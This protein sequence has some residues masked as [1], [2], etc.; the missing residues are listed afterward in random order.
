MKKIN[1]IFPG[2]GSQYVGMG[3]SDNF[4]GLF[5]RADEVLGY[6]LSTLCF[7]GP[8]EDLKL[9]A[10]TQPAIFTHSVALFEKFKEKC[11][12]KFEINAVAGHS[13]GEYAALYAAGIISF[14]DGVKAVNLRGKYMQEATPA[15]VGSM[16]AVMRTE[17]ELIL[18]ACKQASTEDSKVAPANFNEPSQI[19]ISGHKEAVERAVAFI[20]EKNEKAR[21]V[22]LKVS[23]PFHCSLMKPAE[24][25]L[26]AH[27]ESLEFA[28]SKIKYIANVDAKN[29]PIGTSGDLAKE[30]LIKQVCGPVLWTQ[31]M[32][33]FEDDSIFLEVGPNRILK[34]LLRKINRSFKVLSLD[35]EDAWTELGEL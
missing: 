8:E 34:G 21:L 32:N 35:T 15:G 1:L 13:V 31:S 5:S 14:E 6:K 19:V 28:N 24:E 33:N 20:S 26:A 27:F 30:N 4:K 29:Y 17:E 7:D 22:E 9:T 12:D 25:K 3:K 23:A 16:Y 18:Q 11:G 10:N 2:Q